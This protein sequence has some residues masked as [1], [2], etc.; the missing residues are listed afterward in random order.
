MVLPGARTVASIVGA[1]G[2]R[3]P[4]GVAVVLP[5]GRKCEQEAVPIA[6]YAVAVRARDKAGRR[7]CLASIY[8]PPEATA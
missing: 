2:P 5:A 6:G 8:I 1:A 4:G 7:L 3:Q